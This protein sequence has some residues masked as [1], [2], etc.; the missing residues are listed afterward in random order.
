MNR[1]KIEAWLDKHIQIYQMQKDYNDLFEK[2]K[3]I[4]DDD[5]NVSICDGRTDG[6]HLWTATN[7]DFY[8]LIN[9][10]QVTTVF[11][12]TRYDD[13][14]VFAYFYY[15]GYKIFKLLKGGK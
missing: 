4:G 9:I 15:K 13:D 1:A 5:F 8:R 12:S 14:T 6:I 2:K 7:E 11:D 10:L 3:K